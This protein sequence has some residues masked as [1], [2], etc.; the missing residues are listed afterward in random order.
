MSKTTE[1]RLIDANALCE[2]L[3]N[4]HPVVIA[5]KCATTIDDE[6]VRRKMEINKGRPWKH[7]KENN[8]NPHSL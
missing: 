6:P 2:G 8:E 7:G 3:V 1:V 5:A 4:N